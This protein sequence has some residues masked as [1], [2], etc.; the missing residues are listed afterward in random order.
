[1]LGAKVSNLYGSLA[2]NFFSRDFRRKRGKPAVRAKGLWNE[3]K[4]EARNF[5]QEEPR[6]QN[7]YGLRRAC[8]TVPYI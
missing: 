7:D 8:G 5:Q 4:G 1:M 3:P 2:G 6:L